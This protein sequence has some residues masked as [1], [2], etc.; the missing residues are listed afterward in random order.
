M[1]LVGVDEAT[2]RRQDPDAT[3]NLEHRVIGDERVDERLKEKRVDERLKE[4]RV[5]E[6]LKGLPV[7]ALPVA[8][9]VRLFQGLQRQ[10]SC[11]RPLMR[12]SRWER[13]RRP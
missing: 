11:G 1:S 9:A 10:S 8:A 2:D 3:V 5:D 4:K 13:L 7:K 6:R 12:T